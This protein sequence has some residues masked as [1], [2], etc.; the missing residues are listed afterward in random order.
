GTPLRRH[1]KASPFLDE[2]HERVAA[3]YRARLGA[4]QELGEHLRRARLRL[5]SLPVGD[6]FQH[7]VELAAGLRVAGGA[8]RDAAVLRAPGLAKFRAPVPGRPDLGLRC[9]TRGRGRDGGIKSGSGSGSGRSDICLQTA[10]MCISL[11]P[12]LARGLLSNLA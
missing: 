8:V 5:A 11:S 3:L 9:A 10:D 6:R 12:G 2:E 7:Q 4:P 1:A